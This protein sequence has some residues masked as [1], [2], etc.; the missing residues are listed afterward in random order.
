MIVFKECKMGKF[1]LFIVLN[2]MKVYKIGRFGYR[3]C[4]IFIFFI[5]FNFCRKKVLKYEN[6]VFNI[7]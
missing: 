2:V 5:M 4:I 6:I 3:N 7:F 1:K